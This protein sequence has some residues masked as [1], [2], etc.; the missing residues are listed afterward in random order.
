M[1]TEVDEKS[2]TSSMKKQSKLRINR[3]KIYGYCR[4]YL[5]ESF[6]NHPDRRELFL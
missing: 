3:V 6:Q 1:V 2:S 4:Q 5:N